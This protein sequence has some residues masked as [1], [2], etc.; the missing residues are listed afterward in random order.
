MKVIKS[1][2]LLVSLPAAAAFVQPFRSTT[3][4]SHLRMADMETT[5]DLSIPYDAAAKLAYE[6]SDKSMTYD[7]FKAKYEEEAI[8]GLNVQGRQ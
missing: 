3:T 6:S 7:T 1:V 5:T 4:A 8:H 2:L